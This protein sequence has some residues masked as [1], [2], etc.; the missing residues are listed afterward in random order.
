M[1]EF[2][3]EAFYFKV[4]LED[5]LKLRRQPSDE[6]ED[7]QS[8]KWDECWNTVAEDG[9][10]GFCEA[11]G[12]CEGSFWISNLCPHYPADWR[13]SCAEGSS[14][15]GCICLTSNMLA[16][17]WTYATNYYANYG[18][19]ISVNALAGSCHSSN[20]WHYRG[21]TFDVACTT[22]TNHCSALV[23]FV[24]QYQLNELCYPGG[25]C[26][27]HDTWVHAVFA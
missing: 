3:C 7:H 14:P 15:G 23:D 25:P 12:C 17:L 24:R 16:A 1:K 11:E 2:N 10:Y 27:G 6:V 22:P 18:L 13:Y 9:T 8:P 20:S 5:Q 4:P 21:N 19:P 26:S